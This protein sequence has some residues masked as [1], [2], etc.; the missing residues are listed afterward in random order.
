RH[1]GQVRRRPAGEGVED[2]VTAFAAAGCRD[3]EVT[4]GEHAE[5]LGAVSGMTDSHPPRLAWGGFT[6]Q[7]DVAATVDCVVGAAG[8]AQHL[9]GLLDRPA[10]DHAGRV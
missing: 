7:L 4:A 6:R 10:L 5:H 8:P 2:V 1:A 3:G 9:A